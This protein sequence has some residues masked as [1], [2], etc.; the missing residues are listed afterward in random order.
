MKAIKITRL[1]QNSYEDYENKLWSIMEWQAGSRR[2][3]VG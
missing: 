1:E 3:E 2:E